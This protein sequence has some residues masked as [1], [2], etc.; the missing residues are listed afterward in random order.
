MKIFR[1]V[2]AAIAALAALLVLG[3]LLVLWLFDPNDY[4]DYVT[5]W[6]EEQTGRT[7]TIDDSLELEIFPWL[8]VETGGVTIG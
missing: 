5:E 3:I 8:A 7:F 2:G 4:K 6:A 1:Y